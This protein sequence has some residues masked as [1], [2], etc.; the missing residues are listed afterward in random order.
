MLRISAG[1]SLCF[2]LLAV[3]GAL[4]ACSSDSTSGGGSAGSSSGGSSSNAG[5]SGKGSVITGGADDGDGSGTGGGR[6]GSTS[7]GGTGGTAPTDCA[8]APVVCVDAETASTCDPATMMDTSV[9]CSDYYAEVGVV[10]NGCMG[11]A[12]S[13]G[14]T[15]DGLSDKPCSDGVSG[16]A[17]CDETATDD[18]LLN[19]YINCYVDYMGAKA[20]V[21][22]I[23]THVV[24]GQI[25]C[26]AAAADCFGDGAGGAGA[27][28]E[29][30]G[31]G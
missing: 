16:I 10:S 17:A 21:T 3:G 19:V 26:D 20:P 25:D 5:S 2:T 9:N 6:A 15:V 22:C 13:G 29:G 14:C 27:G 8:N 12:L 7:T 24:G 30:G 4:A 18:D 1:V 23:G 31:P 11:D 28:G